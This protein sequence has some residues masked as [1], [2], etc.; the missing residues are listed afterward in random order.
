MVNTCKGSYMMQPSKDAP[1]V[2]ISSP[3]V[4]QEKASSKLHESVLSEFMHVVARLLKK[5]LIPDVLDKLHVDPPSSIHSQE[6]SST[7]GVFIPTPGIPSASNVQPGPSA[8]SLAASPPPFALVD[9]HESVSDVVSGDNT[10]APVRHPND[11]RVEDEVEPQHPNISTEEVPPNDDDNPDVPPTSTDIPAASKPVEKKA[12]QKRR[13]ITIKTGRKKI[14]P[15]IP[16]V[17]IDGISFH[18]EES[19]QHW[20][21]VVQRRIADEVECSPSSPSTDVLASVLSGGTLSTWPVDTGA[22]IY[23]QLSQH[24]DSFGVKIPIALPR[25][26]SNLLLHLNGVVLTTVDTPRPDPKTL[27][28]S[29]RLFQGSHVLDID[30]DVHPSRGPRVFNTSD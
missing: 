17:P 26:F 21:F 24:V 7:K 5:T 2:T 10:T 28:L 19:V 20:K 30:H 25:L 8:R 15:N 11:C 27:A 13:N 16:S 12:Q 4:R 18:H 1:E 23:N 29:Y 14:P 9:A 22:F 3:P 6:S